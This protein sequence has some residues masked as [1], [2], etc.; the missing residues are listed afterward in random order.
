MSDSNKRICDNGGSSSNKKR[1][2]TITQTICKTPKTS[3]N[4][5]FPDLTSDF[6]KKFTRIFCSRLGVATSNI[7]PDIY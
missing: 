3:I 7:K 4:S 6:Y 1:K 5:S 2:T